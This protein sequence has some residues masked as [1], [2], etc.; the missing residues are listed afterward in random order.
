MLGHGLVVAITGMNAKPDNPGPGVAV[1]RCLKESEHF[2]GH[3]I[4]LG[5]DAL[6]PGMYMQN[7]VDESFL[8]PYPSAGQDALLEHIEAIHRHKS[9]DV[10]IPCLDAELPSFIRLVPKLNRMGIRTV[11]PD[12]E[13]FQLR[14]K[15][16]LP[17]LAEHAHIHC[18]ELKTITNSAFFNDCEEKGW[19]FPLMVKGIFY[20]AYL[21][22]HED[23]ARG[24]FRKIA[25]QWGYPVLV[26]KV[27]KGE[28]YNLSSIGD[29]KG[30]LIAPVMM[31]KMAL[32]DK[33]KAWSGVSI[34]DQKLLDAAQ[35]LTSAINWRGP[36]ELEVIKDKQGEYHLIEINPRFPAWIYLSVGVKRNLPEALLHLATNS[37]LPDYQEYLSG[38]LFIRYAE[39]TIVPI[40]E[41]EKIVMQGSHASIQEE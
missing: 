22:N 16:H 1:A 14:N 24:A 26:Q 28:E 37:P 35:S 18:P 36:L 38:I 3:I 29:G 23:E 39:E 4:G 19:E 40:S 2:S 5:Y 15:D 20:D 13:Q 8:L 32:T 17:E 31:K 27:V 6:D 12:A 41:F 10:I 9:I 11:L 30:N 33:G 21:V 25:S 34:F 7:Y